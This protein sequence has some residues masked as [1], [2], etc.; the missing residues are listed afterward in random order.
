MELIIYLLLVLSIFSFILF[1]AQGIFPFFMNIYARSQEKKA[2]RIAEKLEES[3]MFWEKKKLA[4]ISFIPFI[5]AGLGF[6]LTKNP[7]GIIV[8]FFLGLVFPNLMVVIA[9]RKRIMRLQGQLVDSLMILNSALKAGL[10]FVQA[11]EVLCEEMPPPVSQEFNLVLKENSLGVSLEDSLKNFRKRVPLEEVSLFITSLLI[12]RE[13][14]GELTKVFSRLIETIRNNLKLK[15]KVLTLTLQGKL[16][17]AVMMLLPFFFSY[18][19]FKQNPEHFAV[20]LQSQ[21]GRLLL[22]LA[23]ALQLVGIYLIKR[24]STYKL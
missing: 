23:I 12:A 10:S 6:L 20:M 24:I 17:G 4:L 8:G 5:M 19:V 2:M 14:G 22:I 16:Q 15:E 9:T 3:F 13:S 7:I 11:I 18:F 21:N 1:L